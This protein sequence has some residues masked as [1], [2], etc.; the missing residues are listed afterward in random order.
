M[1]RQENLFLD[2]ILKSISNIEEFSE[3]F[4]K[5]ELLHDKLRQS[6]IVRQFEIIGEAVKNISNATREKYPEVEW[7][8]IA[9]SRDI[10]IHGYFMVNWDRVWDMITKHLGIL[11]KQ[12]QII[13]KNME[14]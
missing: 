11:K 2:D 3:G 12:V 5:E 8:Q 14:Q 9:G 1:K 7:K 13:K 6:A 4:T 10:F